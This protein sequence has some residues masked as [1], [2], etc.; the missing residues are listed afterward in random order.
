VQFAYLNRKDSHPTLDGYAKSVDAVFHRNNTVN[1]S[2]FNQLWYIMKFLFTFK[3]RRF[4]AII[5][6]GPL[7]MAAMIKFLSFGRLKLVNTQ[8]SAVILY[9]YFNNR[10]SKRYAY[11]LR[12]LTNYYDLHIC[13]GEIQYDLSIKMLS[14][15]STAKVVESFNGVSPERFASLQNVNYNPNSSV[16]IS[17]S[18]LSSMDHVFVKGFDTMVK[19]FSTIS[20][21]FPELE[22]SHIGYVAP[23]V[24][25]KLKSDNPNANWSKINFVGRQ[26]DLDSWFGNAVAMM[27]LSRLDAFPVAVTESFS[28]SLPTFISDKV[29]ITKMYTNIEEGQLFIVDDKSAVSN[30]CSFLKLNSDKKS[31]ISSSFSQVSTSYTADKA[32]ENFR[33]IVSDNL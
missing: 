31:S 27:H 22:Y 12:H 1:T 33:N 6:N 29:G 10:L 2:A 30:I 26:S 7:P 5:T 14:D 15:K 18:N 8:A 20:N 4:D 9:D 25:L 3:Y 19:I 23:E 16:L 24:I 11:L 13:T 28:A 21:E 32:E 17:L